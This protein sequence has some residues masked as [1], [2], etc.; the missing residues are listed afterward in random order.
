MK[1]MIVW[2][3]ALAFLAA[4]ALLALLVNPSTLP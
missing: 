2:A 1:R 4:A 3:P